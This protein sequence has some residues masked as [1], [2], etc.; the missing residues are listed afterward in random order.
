VFGV[1]PSVDEELLKQKFEGFQDNLGRIM[2]DDVPFVLRAVGKSDED[3]DSVLKDMKALHLT[4]DDMQELLKRFPKH[5]NVLH[6]VPILGIM[7]SAFSDT[8]N[9]ML[10]CNPS[11][12]E[13]R[14]AFGVIDTNKDGKLDKTEIAAALRH[15][16][17][18]ERQIQKFVDSIPPAELDY[19]GF[20]ELVHKDWRPWTYSLGPVPVPNHEKVLDV[21]VL[22]HTLGFVGDL[23]A[24]PTDNTL[25]SSWRY[26]HPKT[27]ATLESAFKRTDTRGS[28]RISKGEVAAALRRWGHREAEIAG[29]LDSMKEE[30]ISFYDFKLLVRGP[31]FSPSSLN[32]VPVLGPALV[33]NV[34]STFEEDIPATEEMR[35]AFE[36]IDK[37]RS[38]KLGKTGIAET[39]RELGTSE[40]MVQRYIDSMEE[41]ELDFDGF[42]QLLE[43][44]SRPVLTELKGVPLPNPAKIHDVPLVGTVTELVQD[45]GL[46][47]YDW[48][49]G[50]GFRAFASYTDNELQEK[51]DEI[52]TSHSGRL[53]RTEISNVLRKLGKTERQIK[54]AYDEMGEH[55]M[56][57]DEFKAS[58]RGTA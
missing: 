50:A 7:T 18:S 25:R 22:G 14:D 8:F 42:L 6:D 33:H 55:K 17:Y 12:E 52:D 9:G 24:Q 56:S 46:E 35:E 43:P 57:F 53:D 28:G 1:N 30:D 38:G 19:D 41:E 49:I 15:L 13:M 40:V 2:K 10:C 23:V 36:Y 34:T 21:P 3:I 37:R 27:E 16:G 4:Y 5:A 47:T 54:R 32:Y 58:I 26:F 29:T 20:V 31:R 51:F 39:L 11:Q 48:T 45:V 44:K